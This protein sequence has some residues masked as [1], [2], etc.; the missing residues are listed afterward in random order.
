MKEIIANLFSMVFF[1]LS[2]YFNSRAK[3]S[4]PKHSAISLRYYCSITAN[5]YYSAIIIKVMILPSN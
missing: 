5:I 1:I 2:L 4:L 3:V